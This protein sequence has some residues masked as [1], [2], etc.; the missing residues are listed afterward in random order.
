[1][2]PGLGPAE[3]SLLLLGVLKRVGYVCLNN[4]GESHFSSQCGILM[5]VNLGSF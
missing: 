4:D 2:G 5:T 3:G 1:M